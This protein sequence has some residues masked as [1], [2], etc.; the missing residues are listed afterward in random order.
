MGCTMEKYDLVD[1]KILEKIDFTQSKLTKCWEKFILSD[2]T[3]GFE[4][5][6]EVFSNIEE[7]TVTLCNL[8]NQND[9]KFD[10]SRIQKLFIELENC[11]KLNNYQQIADLIYY[12]IK[13]EL[14]QWKKIID[15]Y[16]KHSLKGEKNER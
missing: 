2:I 14:K 12:H 1:G 3:E 4:T 13:P 7:L 6:S 9:I 15:K 8:Q 11:M 16:I 10:Y 5:L